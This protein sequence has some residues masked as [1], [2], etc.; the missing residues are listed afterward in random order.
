MSDFMDV[1]NEE[2]NG[3]I[4]QAE[5]CQRLFYKLKKTGK[6]LKAWSKILFSKTK[7]ELHMALGVILRLDVAQ[8]SRA[9][10]DGE[11]DLIRP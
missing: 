11:R 9:L 6:K 2:W 5:P 7:V 8:E 4:N 3:K 10:S 1:I